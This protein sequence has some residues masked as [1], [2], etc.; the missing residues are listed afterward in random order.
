[1]G[2]SGSALPRLRTPAH[3]ALLLPQ[4]LELICEKAVATAGR[5]LGPGEALRRVLECVASGILLPGGCPAP[6]GAPWALRLGFEA[7]VLRFD[8]SSFQDP[9]SR[10]GKAHRRLVQWAPTPA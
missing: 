6:P 3:S 5:P 8:R 9:A 7:V 10:V 4:P 2:L 1:M